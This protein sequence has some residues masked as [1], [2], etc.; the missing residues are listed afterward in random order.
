MFY[1][2]AKSSKFPTDKW[3]LKTLIPNSSVAMSK[4]KCIFV[5]LLQIKDKLH[6]QKSII[7]H[8]VSSY[9]RA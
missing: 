3:R 7:I 4:S 2:V 9:E 6:C 8:G 1:W 5:D